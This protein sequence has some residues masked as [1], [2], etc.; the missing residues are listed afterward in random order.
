[1]AEDGDKYVSSK[2]WHLP[3]SLHGA[4]TEKIIIILTAV[5]T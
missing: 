4:E 1:M 2:H 5:K 3:T